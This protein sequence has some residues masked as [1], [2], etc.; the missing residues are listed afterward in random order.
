VAV[1]NFHYKIF[2]S[3]QDLFTYATTA[4]DCDTIIQIVY[5][6]ASGKFTLFYTGT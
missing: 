5:D 6:S 1:A 2:T 4:A 3:A